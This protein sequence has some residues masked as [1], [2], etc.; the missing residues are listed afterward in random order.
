MLAAALLVAVAVAGGFRWVSSSDTPERP[1]EGVVRSAFADVGILLD[2]LD[3]RSLENRP[4][5]FRFTEKGASDAA[6]ASF[7]VE[8]WRRPVDASFR[9]DTGARAVALGAFRICIRAGLVLGTVR[10]D[11]SA[12][13]AQRVRRAMSELGDATDCAR[14]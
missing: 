12:A 9:E 14:T 5:D 10:M 2:G 7:G 6:A 13:F 4:L 8:V 11:R 1:G 3:Y